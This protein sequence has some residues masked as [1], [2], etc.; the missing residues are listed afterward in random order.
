MGCL[1][2]AYYAGV[3]TPIGTM[4]A[5]KTEKGLCQ[6]HISSTKPSFLAELKHR[7]G[8]EIVLAPEMFGDLRAMLGSYFD[9]E[10]VDFGLPLDLRGTEFQRAIWREIRRIPYG[11]LTSY[12]RLAEAVGVPRGARAAGQA[13]GANPIGIV[14]PCHRV[15]RSDGGMGGFGSQ[16]FMKEHLLSLEGVIPPAKNIEAKLQDRKYGYS[17]GDLVRRFLT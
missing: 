9:G 7:V 12:G 6:M 13:T 8:G 16:I 2:R 10:E 5:A 14:V 15:V 11:K 3:K 1:E 4:W 17:K